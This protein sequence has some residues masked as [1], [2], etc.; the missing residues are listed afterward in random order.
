M[1]E[2]KRRRGHCAY[3]GAPRTSDDHIPPKA[4]FP[5]ERTNLII[6]PSC[7]EHNLDQSGFDEEFRNY[8]ATKIGAEIPTTRALFEKT[9]RSVTRRKNSWSWQPD[10]SAFAVQ[11]E[12]RPFKPVIERITRGLYW[13]RYRGES[14]PLAVK[15]QIGQLR[16]GEWLPGF[17]SDMNRF[18]VAGDQFFCAYNRM[19]DYPTISIWVYAFHRRLIAMALTDVSHPVS[20]AAESEADK[21]VNETL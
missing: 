19:D 17:V 13:H 18:A 4:L 8:I 12:S 2:A 11:I 5:L 20:I 3:C 6:V 1:G 7:H 9:V 15:M 16:I 10:L 21:I 14:L